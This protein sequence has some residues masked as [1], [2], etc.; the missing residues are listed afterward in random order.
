MCLSCFGRLARYNS[1]ASTLEG[2]S[3]MATVVIT[4]DA[5]NIE[6][7]IAE[8]LGQIDLAALVRGKLVAVKP[9]ETS[10]SAED[11]SGV[12]QPDTLRAVLQAV[13]RAQ[14]RE[15]VVSGGSGAG[16]T[17]DILRVSGMLDVLRAEGVELFDHNRPPFKEVPLD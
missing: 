10:A 6:H 9:N 8:A 15:L 17:E 4:H 16:E 13:K 3:P 2:G 11:K 14:P 12:T 7:A 5:A 1:P